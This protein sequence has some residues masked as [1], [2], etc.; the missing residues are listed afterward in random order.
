MKLIPR[1]IASLTWRMLTGL[2]STQI[3]PMSAW[4]TP[5]RIFIRVDLPAPFSPMSATTSPGSMEND[6]ESSASTQGKRLVMFLSSISD[7]G[8]ADFGFWI[9][10]LAIGKPQSK[11]R[12]PKSAILLLAAQLLQVR[13]ELIDLFLVDRQ[14]R[15]DD[16]L[17]RGNCGL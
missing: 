5:P 16:R 15:H 3:D 2:S 12:N 1:R 10:D 13:R 6:T 8:I 17:A 7:T 4:C 9:A 11:I 14:R